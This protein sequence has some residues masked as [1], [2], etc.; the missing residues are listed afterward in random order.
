MRLVRYH[1]GDKPH[2]IMHL[3]LGVCFT[4]KTIISILNDFSVRIFLNMILKALV[5]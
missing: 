3:N 1:F 5:T 4:L 2:S